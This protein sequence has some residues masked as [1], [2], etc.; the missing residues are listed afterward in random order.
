MAVSRPLGVRVGRSAVDAVTRSC[1]PRPLRHTA[2]RL[3]P[4]SK[5]AR[6]AGELLFRPYSRCLPP[7]QVSHAAIDACRRADDLEHSGAPRQPGT[8]VWRP[9]RRPPY[10]LACNR[11]STPCG[12]SKVP[13]NSPWAGVAAPKCGLSARPPSPLC[14]AA[15]LQP[16]AQPTGLRH[17]GFCC[18]TDSHR[19]LSPVS[20]PDCRATA[21]CLDQQA[22]SV[23]R[24]AAGSL[25]REII[26]NGVLMDFENS[27]IRQHF[28][29]QAEQRLNA[30]NPGAKPEHQRIY[31][32]RVHDR[33]KFA[34][35]S[36]EC[37][38]IVGNLM[39]YDL[40]SFDRVD[41]TRLRAN[42]ENLFRKYEKDVFRHTIALRKQRSRGNTNAIPEAQRLF[43]TKM[44]NVFRN[45][46]NIREALSMLP[47]RL[48]EFR[49]T[50]RQLYKVFNRVMGG[51]KPQQKYLVDKL[52]ISECEYDTWL[53]SL[54]FLLQPMLP[55]HPNLYEEIL[56]RRSGDCDTFF[57]VNVFTYSSDFCLLSDKGYVY[58]SVDDDVHQAWCFNLDSS[59]FVTYSYSEIDKFCFGREES[60]VY[61]PRGGRE[62]VKIILNEE[63]TPVRYY[64]DDLNALRLYNRWVLS[65]CHEHV[66]CASPD[67]IS[68]ID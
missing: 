2:S 38:K 9:V 3:E 60:K 34:V 22:L 57:M 25:S 61:M 23:P 39:L 41:N 46:F 54:F 48:I 31:Q 35:C 62:Q 13:P 6:A 36:P 26:G 29:S 16:L 4:Q 66:Y 15:H 45:P 14:E 42:F 30:V 7:V 18:D 59:S 1:G 50:D 27:T 17:A 43:L 12:Y 44:L 64:H 47:K 68:S 55:G 65:Q 33:S 32:F 24:S 8:T 10:Q 52:G 67:W 11:P 21:A 56:R 58:V 51:S 40:F 19:W 53:R 37:V 5:S 28:L 63:P 20:H 49:P